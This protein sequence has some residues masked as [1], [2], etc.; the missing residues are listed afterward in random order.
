[1][2]DKINEN[3]KRI[4]KNTIMLYFRMILLLLVSLYSARVVL[5][6]LGIEDYGIYNVVGGFVTMFGFLNATLSTSTQRY[7]NVEIGKGCIDN[8]KK[9]FSNALLLHFILVGIVL[10]IAETIG[11]WFV[12]EK[13]VISPYRENAALWVYQFSVIAICVQIIQLPF[14]STIIAHERMNIYAYV[15]IY[16][17]LAKL[18]IVFLVQVIAADRLIIYGLLF[19]AVQVSVALI[20]N[21]Y[22]QSKFQEARFRFGYDKELFKDMLGF[23]GWNVIGN[24]AS[25]GNSQGMNIL[26]NIFFGAAVN[27]ARGVA[28]QV[29]SLFQQLI[30]SFQLAVKP[31]VIKY[32]AQGQ[33]EEMT[34]LV[35]NSAKIS[36]FLVMVLSIP[37]ILE[38]RPLLSLWLG[39]YPDY[40][41]VFVQIILF[42]ALI[43]SMTGNIVMVVHASGYLKNVGIFA[44][45]TLLLALPI[46]YLLL[47]MGCSPVIPFVV[48]IFAALGEAYFELYWMKRY[49][50]FPKATF[51]KKVY[52]PVFLIYSVSFSLSFLF[53]HFINGANVYIQMMLVGLFSVLLSSL[54]V[55]IFGLTAEMRKKVISFV[56]R[57]YETHKK[58]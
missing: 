31:Q 21:I 23:S 13:L 18:G 58:R 34:K 10:L 55:Y 56:C 33:T 27:A 4:A 42:R 43:T 49:I 50:N 6:T 46:S 54:L 37:T 12:K 39:E 36:A 57:K 30:N 45:G 5:K 11:L 19:L 51:Y 3:N 24:L 52:V 15:S 41:P 1:M 20:Y 9:I 35:F 47:R 48:N 16:E 44:G 7:L 17:A 40:A 32:Y 8:T 22:C 29:H 53:H 2:S 28:F 25:V 26:L 14:M 38:I